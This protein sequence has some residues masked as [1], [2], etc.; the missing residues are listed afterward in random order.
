MDYFSSTLS[1]PLPTQCIDV[2]A[3]DDVQALQ[4]TLSACSVYP[5]ANLPTQCID[6]IQAILRR[7][8]PKLSYKQLKGQKRREKNKIKL[9][10]RN[11]GLEH[12][13]YTKGKRPNGLK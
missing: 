3:V 10:T 2:C 11:E 9:E 5:S 6:I 8:R 7:Q 13:G 4:P 12:K 1:S